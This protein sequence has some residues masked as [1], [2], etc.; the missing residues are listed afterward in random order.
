VES[1]GAPV[2]QGIVKV[3]WSTPW[4]TAVSESATVSVSRS[5]TVAAGV[6]APGHLGELTQYVPFEL[7]DDLLEQTGSVQRRLRELPSRVGGALRARDGDVPVA[8]VRAG[9]GQADR[10]VGR[11]AGAEPVGEGAAG[12][13]PADRP[14]R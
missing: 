9:V 4:S 6:Y 3:A 10:R 5:T 13:A 12:P 14:G 1:G 7:V 11:A 8:R 2:D